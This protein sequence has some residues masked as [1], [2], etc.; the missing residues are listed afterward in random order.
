[1]KRFLF[2]W[3]SLALLGGCAVIRPESST[4]LLAQVDDIATGASQTRPAVIEYDGK[5]AMLYSTKDGRVAFQIGEKRQLLDETARVKHGGSFFQLHRHAQNLDAL[6][7]SHEDGKNLYFTSST[8]GGER[9]TPVGMVNDEHGILTPYSLTWGPQGIVGITYLD[10]RQPN[11]QVYFNR[12]TDYGRTWARPD[13]RLDSPPDEGQAS[14]VHEPQS[15]ATGTAWVSAWTDIVHGTMKPIYCII[16]RRSED[17]GLNW[18]PPEVL[19]SSDRQ[20]S[21]LVVRAQGNS[22]VIAADEYERGIFALTSQ[23]EG[24]NWRAAGLL[25]GS[26]HASN[27]GIDM[28]LAAG[29]AHLVWMQ[30][31]KDEKTRIMRAS[32]DIAQSKWLDAVQRLDLKAHENTRSLSPVVLATTQGP[33][34]AAWVDYRD[35]RP[36]IYLSAS[37]DQGQAWSAPQ[38]LLEP[39][40]LSAGWPR[41]IPWRDQAAIAYE[42][43]PTDRVMDGKFVVRLLPAGNGAK[44]LPGLP[45]QSQISEDE[46]KARLEQRVKSLWETRVAG[47]YEPTY[48]MFD[49]AYKAAIPKKNYLDTVGV[50]TFLSFSVDDISI[51]GN[52]A[53]VK[54]KIKYEVKPTMLPIAG[55]KTITV[56]PVEV[57]ATNTWVWVDNDWYMVFAPSYEPPQL[58]Y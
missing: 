5:P 46:R 51:K 19:Y 4:M 47:N 25:A 13:Q 35:I 22:I 15:V 31:R 8:D 14:Y 12:S 20:I 16:S 30:D 24:R 3:A 32:L 44:G 26:S 41:L 6:W 58:K 29:R 48:D 37:Y 10:E 42:I 40:K 53:S 50:I 34:I 56:A 57:D 43:Y 38:A 11:Y 52:E 21:S 45:G 23:D 7:W 9:F 39:G 33:L 17:A 54:M 2:V 1:M 18:T 49:F 28:A 36:N 55:G 27:S